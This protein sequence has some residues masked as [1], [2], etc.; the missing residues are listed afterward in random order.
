MAIQTF[1]SVQ[2][3]VR[4]PDGTMFVNVMEDANGKPFQ[5]IITIGKNGS[6]P[7]AWAQALASIITAALQSGTKME[8]ILTELS[9]ISTDREVGTTIHSKCTS[10]PMGVWQAL[11]RYRNQRFKELETSL[12]AEGLL[13]NLEDEDEHHASVSRV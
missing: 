3:K 13:D 11:V 10:G 9:Q 6:S 7:A 12:G 1:N 8:T 2:M 4:T 5:V